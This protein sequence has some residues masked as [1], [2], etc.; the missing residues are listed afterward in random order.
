M[1]L[2]KNIINYIIS[3][4]DPRIKDSILFNTWLL[5][6]IIFSYFYFIFVCGPRFMKNRK[7]YSLKTFIRYYNVFQIMINSFIV[8]ILISAGW[9]TTIP[10]HC[11]PMK[12]GTDP[13]SMK[14][15]NACWCAYITKLIDLIETGIFVLRKKDQ[16]ISFLHL[17]HHVS[18]VLISWLFGRHYSDGMG[19]FLPLVN[20]SVHV[21]MYTYYF[22][23]TFGPNIRKILNRYKYFLTIIQ[24]VQFII[25][26]CYIIQILL[27]SCEIDNIPGVIMIINLSINFFLFYNFYR[28]TY[29]T[30]KTK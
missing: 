4:G 25:L 15:L 13:D 30:K 8:Y 27:P 1:H 19:T 12:Y 2:L 17:Y 9:F 14:L 3:V 16:Q 5:I 6:F 28:K 20:C 29:L 26:I 21:I 11:I 24:M 7:P 10:L 23:S 22:F 18:T